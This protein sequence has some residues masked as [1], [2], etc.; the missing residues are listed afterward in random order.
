VLYNVTV[1]DNGTIS[2]Y[3]WSSNIGWISFESSA[4]AG[5]PSGSCT[6]LVDYAHPSGGTYPVKGWARACS[7]FNS[8][9]SGSLKTVATRGD[10]GVSTDPW[11]GFISLSGTA[12]NG[13]TYGAVVNSAKTTMTGYVWG[14]EVMG[15]IQMNFSVKPERKP[16]CSDG[17]DNAD[18]E[19]TLADTADPG[20]H[21]DGNA[22]NPSSYDPLDPD[23]SNGVAASIV[24]F[25]TQ[26]VEKNVTHPSF[27]W[28]TQNANK[29]RIYKTSDGTSGCGSSETDTAKCDY[30]DATSKSNGQL[31]YI[32]SSLGFTSSPT[33]YTLEC[34]GE[35]GGTKT[36]AVTVNSCNT[37]TSCPTGQH[38]DA[39]G[40]CVDDDDGGGGN[41]GGG[42]GV[43]GKP[44]CSDGAD[45]DGD[46]K[47]DYPE[48]P[49]C[50]GP[51]DDN[52]FNAIYDEH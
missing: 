47:A 49:G 3:A 46:G 17:V 45:N 22:G 26:C 15:W 32:Q 36:K 48:D 1:A 14:S 24:T 13:G 9:C 27:A 2:G 41:P 25:D 39:N 12:K 11:D 21:T 50:S 31:Q 35:W 44:Q 42:T 19:D 4:L 7:V 29:C 10:N 16:E 20:C 52:E 38:K 18:A 23:E 5:C 8:G 51:N 30:V 6:A 28:D 37:D 40:K 34:Y 33:S 43:D